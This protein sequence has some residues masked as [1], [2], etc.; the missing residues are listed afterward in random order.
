AGAADDRGQRKRERGV[1]AI[2]LEADP[3]A[4]AEI[5]ERVGRGEDAEPEAAELARQRLGDD[6]LFQRLHDGDAPPS[7]SI[8]LVTTPSADPA[9][10]MRSLP[11]RSPR[12]PTG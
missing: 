9:T 7:A 6:G 10:R 3:Q 8:A 4:G 12:R 5:A 2:E 11:L 1:A